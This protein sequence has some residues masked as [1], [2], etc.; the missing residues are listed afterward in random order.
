[1]RQLIRSIQLGQKFFLHFAVCNQVPKQNEL[2]KQINEAL[3]D[4]KIK[5]INF[6]KPI[7]DLLGEINRQLKGKKYD[8]VF[9]QGLFYSISSD[10]KGNENKLIHSLNITRD[11]FGKELSCPMYLWLPEYAF[12]K[13]ARNAPD[14]FSVRSGGYYFSN[15]AEKITETIFQQFSG[16][17][18]E[19]SNLAIEEKLNRI[20]VLEDLLAEFLGLP[21]EKRDKKAEIHLFSE[22]ALLNLSISENKKSIELTEKSI[23]LYI[24]TGDKKNE[25]RF[26]NVLGNNYSNLNDYKK[27]NIYYEKALELAKKIEDTKLE[28]RALGNLGLVQIHFEKYDKAIEYQDKSLKIA[29]EIGDLSNK[30][31]QL[32]NK[33]LVYA[34]L[35]RFEKAI[36]FSEKGLK[37][38]KEIG[39]REAIGS[40]SVNL[41]IVYAIA[42]EYQKSIRFIKRAIEIAEEGGNT[43]AVAF[44]LG[45]LGEIYLF[46]GDQ[47]LSV[48]YLSK[49]VNLKQKINEPI[50]KHDKSNLFWANHIWKI[51][52]IFFIMII[53]GWIILDY[54]VTKR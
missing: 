19:E 18:L 28:G 49:S 50:T 8:A 45:F 39:D 33:G 15:T 29:D 36:E 20:R 4:K 35:G 43:A 13:I 16:T 21:I 38:A 14:F 6:N 31:I 27:A 37:I 23:K 46:R 47:K 11:R 3:P 2:I 24:E 5:I 44:L 54:L 53:I 9:I 48:K 52:I 41:G 42:G 7:T 51:R 22:L 10:G 32:S 17:V 1:L 30:S 25:A 40:R 34:R 12:A 26:L